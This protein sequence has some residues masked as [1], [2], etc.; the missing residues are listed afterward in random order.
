MT[1]C[2]VVSYPDHIFSPRIKASGDET[3]YETK[4]ISA[5]LAVNQS[6]RATTRTQANV[7]RTYDDRTN[8]RQTDIQTA[9]DIIKCGARSSSPQINKS[10]QGEG[11]YSQTNLPGLNLRTRREKLL[12]KNF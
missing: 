7:S 5:V 4:V 6:A 12:E 8:E 2:Q 9:V 3:G 10:R 11:F 1:A